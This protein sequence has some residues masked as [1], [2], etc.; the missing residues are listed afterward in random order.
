MNKL[1]RWRRNT[2]I[3]RRIWRRLGTYT[4]ALANVYTHHVLPHC[5]WLSVCSHLNS[6]C[7]PP[8]F[9][10]Y[11]LI[12]NIIEYSI[13]CIVY[14]SVQRAHCAAPLGSTSRITVTPCHVSKWKYHCIRLCFHSS[15]YIYIVL[16][17]GYWI[18]TPIILLW[19]ELYVDRSS[20]GKFSVKTFLY[21]L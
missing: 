17:N 14:C 20:Q 15:F 1:C 7:K 11:V 19:M 18:A 3:Y 21:V 5:V 13:V 16:K 10:P 4:I 8:I 9:W 12:C 2:Q 6:F